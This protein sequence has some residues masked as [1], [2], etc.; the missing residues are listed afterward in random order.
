MKRSVVLAAAL[1]AMVAV[2][3]C[4]GGDPTPEPRSSG[5]PAAGTPVATV[6]AS[7]EPVVRPEPPEVSLAPGL[8]VG[9]QTVTLELPPDVEARYTLD[10][11]DPTA[12]SALR[13]D[14]PFE[15]TGDVLLRAAAAP[16]AAP[17]VTSDE[18]QA[19]YR[20]YSQ[21]IDLDEPI[22]LAGDEVL[23]FE[24]AYVV[25]RG[26]IRLRDRAQLVLRD[27]MLLHD[28]DHS[29]QYELVAEGESQVVVQR[30]GVGTVCNGSLNWAFF[31]DSR[32]VATEMDPTY[33]ECNT[34][35]FLSGRSQVQVDGWDTFSATVCNG[36]QVEVHRSETLE[37]EFCLSSGVVIDTTLPAVIEGE[38]VFDREDDPGA[39]YSL[40]VTDSVV[41]GWGINMLPGTDL[42]VRDGGAV[43]IA[44]ITGLPWDNVTVEVEGL[45]SGFYP[46]QTWQ[47]HDSRLR[48][49]N[50]EVY[51]WEPNAFHNNTIIIRD[52]DYTGSMVNSG[53]AH[54]EIID[55]RVK[56]LVAAERVTMTVRNS[57]ITG[58]VV[59]NDDSE[60]ILIDS[61]VELDDQGG[62][63]S[64]IAT[65][66]GR[67]ILR[68]TVVEG[69]QATEG[70]GEI[71]V[72]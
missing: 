58:D 5:T 69:R 70:N 45:R 31:D 15:V 37:L 44:I 56:L 3:G 43:T 10:G 2:L 38:F 30:S 27:S 21:R 24:D 48:L 67:I 12:T 4:D 52:S 25:H 60:I 54:Y 51:G 65:G 57:V 66:N 8:Y 35:N 47:V 14:G 9:A 62:Q 13:Y 11:S 59:A 23:L 39:E 55:S 71:V 28:K 50:T 16:E 20:V 49:I 63:G 32:L 34:W 61:R 41:D 29:F 22:D 46:D 72:E 6:Q 53:T 33:A 26:D 18:A 42:T 19:R 68:N 1:L 36:A 7:V 17:G 64:V 40:R